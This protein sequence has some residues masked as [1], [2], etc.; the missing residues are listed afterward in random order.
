[1]F[2]EKWSD[3]L[4]E[5]V[6][7]FSDFFHAFGLFALIGLGL[8]IPAGVAYLVHQADKDN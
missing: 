5:M 1:M 2:L 4:F 6:G 3:P 7:N 8:A